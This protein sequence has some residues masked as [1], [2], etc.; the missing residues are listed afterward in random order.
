[1]PFLKGPG[2]MKKVK[3]LK[4]EVNYY[5]VPAWEKLRK[6]YIVR[7]PICEICASDGW[8]S[9]AQEVHHILPIKAVENPEEQKKRAYDEGN[10]ISVCSYCHHALHLLLKTDSRSYFKKIYLAKTDG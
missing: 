9:M 2:R 8:S 4:P 1:M 6:F 10:L 5:N 7:H 3:S